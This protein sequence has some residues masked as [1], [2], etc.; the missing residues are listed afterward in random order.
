MFPDPRS[1]LHRES[2]EERNV[3]GKVEGRGPGTEGE[4]DDDKKQVERVPGGKGVTHFK[5]THRELIT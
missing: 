4:T 1:L 3:Q 2:P 5:T